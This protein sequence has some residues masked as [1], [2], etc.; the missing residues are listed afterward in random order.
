MPDDIVGEIHISNR[1]PYGRAL[2][3]GLQI[4]QAALFTRFDEAVSGTPG[5]SNPRDY[6]VAGVTCFFIW[7][8]FFMDMGATLERQ[9]MLGLAAWTYLIILLWG[10]DNFVRLQVIIAVAF[11]T[12]GEHFASVYMQGYIYRFDNVPAFVPPGHGAVYL[13]AVALARSHLFKKYARHI[14][15]FVLVTGGIWSVW[16]AFFATRGDMLGLCLFAAF[17][18]CVFLGRSPL[19]YLGAFFITTWLELIGTH[20]GNWYWVV[21]EPIFGLS[22]GNPPSGVAAWYCMVDWVALTG[23]PALLALWSRLRLRAKRA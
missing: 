16:G 4:L 1:F 14:L 6:I 2:S 9:N 15:G 17:T 19:V 21:Y 5:R 12:V 11:A 18:L 20:L 22:Q 23:A 8:C 3:S 13:S 10:E 7:L